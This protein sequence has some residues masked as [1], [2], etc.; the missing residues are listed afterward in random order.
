MQEDQTCPC[1]HFSTVGI[2][3]P[4][5]V[6]GSPTT[7][8]ESTVLC[9]GVSDLRMLDRSSIERRLW[10]SI[11]ALQAGAMSSLVPIRHGRAI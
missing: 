1:P 8:G 5:V 7:C 10:N 3:S 2:G 6:S 9:S 11:V 4:S